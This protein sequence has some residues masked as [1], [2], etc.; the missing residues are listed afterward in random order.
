MRH[1]SVPL[2]LLF[3]FPG[4]SFNRSTFVPS[5]PAATKEKATSSL[6]LNL[7]RS[8]SGCELMSR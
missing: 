6:P 5:P 4:R 2:V 7:L 1:I 8:Q 3:A